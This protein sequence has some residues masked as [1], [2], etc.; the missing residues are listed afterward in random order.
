MN[1]HAKE[2]GVLHVG[3][4]LNCGETIKDEDQLDRHLRRECPNRLI[5]CGNCDLVIQA[6]STE[7]HSCYEH[8]LGLIL[9]TE[10]KIEE[11]TKE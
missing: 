9:E 6:D 3:C 4:P 10:K 8:L 5:Q 1:Q 11:K 2:C 7:Q